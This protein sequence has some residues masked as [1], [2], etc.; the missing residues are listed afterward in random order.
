MGSVR[1]MLLGGAVLLSV[2]AAHTQT[3]A[4]I[5]RSELPPIE[6]GPAVEPGAPG[7]PQPD[8]SLLNVDASTLVDKPIL[9][10]KPTLPSHVGSDTAWSSQD[11]GNAEALSVKQSL[12]PFWDT[13]VG[14]DMTVVRQSSTVT[15]RDLLQEKFGPDGQ[16]QSSSAAWA[17]VTAPGVGQVWDKTAIEARVDPTQDQRKITTSMSK[18]VPLGGDQY[19]LTLQ[20]GYNVTEQGVAPMT[21]IAGHPLTRS[22]GVDQSAKLSIADTGTSIIAGQSLSS[23]DDK[24]LRTVGAEQKIFGGVSI[25]G[26][27]SETAQGTANKSLTAGFKRSW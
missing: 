22:Y 26:S 13:R 6:S 16:P 14:A 7:E 5:Q 4:L 3:P 9:P 12:S 17:A 15:T 19:S 10:K 23:A 21:T 8:W 20:N 24:W 27:I 1:L 18:S 11:K 2:N 25:T